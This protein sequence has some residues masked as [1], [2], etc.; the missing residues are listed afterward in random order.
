MPWLALATL[1]N[2]SDVNG[3][4]YE[5]I[6]YYNKDWAA[7]WLHFFRLKWERRQVDGLPKLANCHNCKQRTLAS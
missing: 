2:Q 7:Y 3:L 1:N 5:I 6:G 4:E